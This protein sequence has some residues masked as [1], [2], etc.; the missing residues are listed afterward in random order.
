MIMS[1]S[2]LRSLYEE[3]FLLLEKA[4]S[5]LLEARTQHELDARNLVP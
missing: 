4:Q 2:E 1:E 3:C 5:L